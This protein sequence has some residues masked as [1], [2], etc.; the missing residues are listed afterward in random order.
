MLTINAE[1]FLRTF[2]NER[3]Q[4]PLHVND[5]W[6]QFASEIITDEIKCKCTYRSTQYTINLADLDTDVK[7]D[8][9]KRCIRIPEIYQPIKVT[10]VSPVG[11]YIIFMQSRLEPEYMLPFFNIYNSNLT[12][13]S[14]YMKNP[15][16]MI[17]PRSHGWIIQCHL[18]DPMPMKIIRPGIDLT[19][20][21]NDMQI[22]TSNNIY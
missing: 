16:T 8:T 2:Y 9:E 18:T 11:F 7:I 4:E 6:M 5:N 17:N 22:I 20:F 12:Y 19:D 3:L 10:D 13:E 1:T 21:F 15:I 14:V